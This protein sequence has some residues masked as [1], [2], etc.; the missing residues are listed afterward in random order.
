MS[1]SPLTLVHLIISLIGIGSGFI[2]LFGMFAG[3]RIDGW[4][5]LSL[6]TTILTSVTGFIFFHFEKVT[7]GIILGVLSLIALGIAVYA[8]YS[9]KLAGGWRSTFV[10]TAMIAQWFN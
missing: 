4:T 10:V 1:M 2:V 9:K 6:T 3:K 8:C 5:V 7:P